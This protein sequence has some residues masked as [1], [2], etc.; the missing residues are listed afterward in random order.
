[1]K[2]LFQKMLMV[3]LA[4]F[5]SLSFASCGDD[6]DDDDN[7]NGAMTGWVEIEGTKYNFTFFK[8][9]KQPDGSLIIDGYSTKDYREVGRNGNYNMVNLRLRYNQDGTLDPEGVKGSSSGNPQFNFIIILNEDNSVDK[10]SKICYDNFYNTTDRI[11]GKLSGKKITIDGVDVKL[12][13]NSN[14][15]QTLDGKRNVWTDFHFEGV[16]QNW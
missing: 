16:P 4:A 1:M 14:Y 12:N 3:M 8:A 9:D 13:H 6:D 2:T 5:L 7:G 10:S 11:Q 15:G